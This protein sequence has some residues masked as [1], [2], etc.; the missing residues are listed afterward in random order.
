MTKKPPVC[1]AATIPGRFVLLA[2]KF[3]LAA[4]PSNTTKLPT[5]EPPACLATDFLIRPVSITTAPPQQPSVT[6]APASAPAPPTA[7]AESAP[8]TAAGETTT[9]GYG[10]F[11]ALVYLETHAAPGFQFVCPGNA[12]GQEAMTCDDFAPV[13]P[14][15]KV[16]IISDPCPTAYMNEAS[17]SWVV[18]GLSESRIDPFGPGC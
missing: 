1:L 16:I 4:D 5:N 10:C 11:P 9:L 18:E 17:N 12:L 3:Q 15:S 6:A 13:C 7:P 14:G 2:I 8:S